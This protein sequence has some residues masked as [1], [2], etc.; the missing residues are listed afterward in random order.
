MEGICNV[1]LIY[2]HNSSGA[3]LGTV[4]PIH[5]EEIISLNPGQYNN[6]VIYLHRKGKDPC[7]D[8]MDNQLGLLNEF[9]SSLKA[10]KC[11]MCCWF[12][13]VFCPSLGLTS[14][15][16]RILASRICQRQIQHPNFCDF[17]RA[18]HL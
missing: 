15:G 4:L 7:A 18:I 16:F 14:G 13:V 11:D 1:T 9:M 5:N 12:G 8:R 2:A 10:L 3:L 17:A 6:Y